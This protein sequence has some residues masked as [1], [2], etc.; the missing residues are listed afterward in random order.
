MSAIL[1]DVTSQCHMT[2]YV[3]HFAS[4]YCNNWTW[5]GNRLSWMLQLIKIVL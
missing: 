5:C 3:S 4:F 2:W 1:G